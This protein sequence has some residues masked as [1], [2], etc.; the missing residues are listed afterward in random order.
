MS[1]QPDYRERLTE[2][3][4]RYERRPRGFWRTLRNVFLFALAGTIALTAHRYYLKTGNEKLTQAQQQ[5]ASAREQRA[6]EMGMSKQEYEAYVRRAARFDP[7][8][9]YSD[10]ERIKII[11]LRMQAEDATSLRSP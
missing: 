1:Y 11:Q 4:W 9:P 3:E 5:R 10:E 2:Q 6:V 8:A 7:G